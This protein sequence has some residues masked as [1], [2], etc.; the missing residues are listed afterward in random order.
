METRYDF[1]PFLAD[2]R[3]SPLDDD[4]VLGAWLGTMGAGDALGDVRAYGADVVGPLWELADEVDRPDRLPVIAEWDAHRRRA[5]TPVRLA[6]GIPALWDASFGRGLGAPAGDRAADAARLARVFLLAQLGEVG[7]VCPLA[8]TEGLVR[9]VER[10]GGDAPRSAARRVRANQ[11]G[12]VVHG[13]QFVTEIHAGSDAGRVTLDATPAGAGR[14]T[15]DGAKWFCSNVTADYWIVLARTAGTD[16]DAQ[17]VLVDR[18]EA[19]AA[20]AVSVDRLKDKLGTRA[21]ATAEVTLRGAPAMTVG[22]PGRGLAIVV[23]VVLTTSRVWTALSSSAFATMAARGARAYARFRTAFGRAIGEMPLV[24]AEVER[25]TREAEE[26][27]AG[28]LATTA[29]WL[30]ATAGGSDEGEERLVRLLVSLTK[31]R[32]T[33]RATRIVH[34]AMMVLGGNGIEERFSPLPRLLRDA[35]INETWEGPHNLLCAQAHKDL[36][37]WHR[38]DL[39]A[40]TLDALLDGAPD[41]TALRDRALALLAEPA[42][43]AFADVC[44][45]LF[46]AHARTA[47]A[48]LTT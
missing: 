30:G 9:V 38:K 14:V 23:G 41:A 40:P 4:R 21:L 3:T 17:L 25:V 11:P 35:V 7:T 39:A 15:L 33:T 43:P 1:A 13:A 2:L 36:A 8:C 44:D 47:R 26:V 46:D 20:G 27:E 32:V 48:R 42:G 6:P 10:H 45:A 31:R 29:R 18:A 34:D 28:T 19:E 37:G 12:R 22:E 24:R 5:S 16:S